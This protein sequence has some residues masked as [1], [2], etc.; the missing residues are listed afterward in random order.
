L[1]RDEF[2]PVFQQA[3]VRFT[4]TAGPI[5]DVDLRHSLQQQYGALII[6]AINN[7]QRASEMNGS[8]QRPMLLL[9]RLFR[10]RAL[11][12]DTQEQYASDMHL[13]D[14]WERQFLAVG[15]HLDK[16]TRSNH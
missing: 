7:A 9:S 4:K 8:A 5:P 16:T 2:G 6:D 3:K 14:D 13:A 1:E 12:R 10:E 15:G 11:I